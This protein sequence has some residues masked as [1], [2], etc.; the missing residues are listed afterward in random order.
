MPSAGWRSPG[1]LI[2]GLLLAWLTACATAPPAL[3]RPV[4]FVGAQAL[5]AATL[6]EV[7]VEPMAT[8]SD[9]AA[10]RSAGAAAIARAYHRLGYAEVTVAAADDDGGLAFTIEEGRRF[11]IAALDVSGNVVWPRQE[12]LALWRVTLLPD[13]RAYEGPAFTPGAP[14]DPEHLDRFAQLVLAR[15]LDAGYLDARVGAPRVERNVDARTVS[16]TVSVAHEGPRYTISNYDV[17]DAVRAVLG[18]DMPKAP[19]GEFC[20]RTRAEGF[21]AAVLDGLRRRGYPEPELRVSATRDASRGEVEL[22]LSVATGPPRT[23][24]EVKVTGNRRVPTDLVRDKFGVRE[25]VRFDGDAERRG[26]AALSATGEF[27]RVDVEYEQVA[28]DKVAVIVDTTETTGLVLKGAPYL[29][30]WRRF[31]YNLFIE[32]RNALGERHDLLGHV[33]V[34]HRGYHTGARYL[35]SGLLGDENTTFTLGGDFY[36]NERVAFTDRGAGGTVELR[37]YF[38]PGL[39][40]AASYSA[41]AHF[42]TT[43]DASTTTSVGRDYTEGRAALVLDFDRTDNRLLPT[44]GQRA[45]VKLDRVDDALGA[46][47]EFTRL[48][49]GAGVWLPVSERVRLS[50]EADSGWLWPG[51][52][53]AAVPIPERFFLG[54][55]DTVRSFRESR[56]GPRDPTF[57]LRGGECKNFARTEMVVR[58]IEP[59][60]LALF[61]DAG[62]L[63]IDVADWSLHDMRYALGVA[64][65]LVARDT[66]PVVLSAAYNPDRARGEDEWVVDFAAGVNF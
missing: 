18:D 63:G 7:L 35:H 22:R 20:T 8:A 9:A 53:S 34:G 2:A 15:Y 56:L 3:P 64:V 11:T 62:N 40:V 36:A 38:S 42:A 14:F 59:V 32:G 60:D 48:R 47:V 13:G 26:V 1:C 23:V 10:M 28:E 43:F 24:V 46:D 61:A 17:P 45:Y 49:L 30:P 5:S 4:R 58:T 66:G 54:G 25:G 29:H 51:Q 31:G 50:L 39:S 41:L 65:R 12:L 52:G 44:R 6:R 55:Y 16:A 33:H 27:S 57:A 21:A 19:V 37:R